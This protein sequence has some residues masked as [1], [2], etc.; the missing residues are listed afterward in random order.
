MISGINVQEVLIWRTAFYLPLIL[1]QQKH[2]KKDAV[3]FSGKNEECDERKDTL[4]FRNACSGDTE[5]VNNKFNNTAV[6]TFVYSN[7]L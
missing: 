5:I 3:N 6:V 2:I 7:I 1:Q 4:N